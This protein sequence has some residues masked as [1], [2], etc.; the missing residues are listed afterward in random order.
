MVVEL[1]ELDELDVVV[2]VVMVVVDGY[3]NQYALLG[4]PALAPGPRESPY[5]CLP[6]EP[7]LPSACPTPIFGPDLDAFPI[8]ISKPPYAEV[9]VVVLDDDEVVV[10][11]VEVDVVDSVVVV[12][13]VPCKSSVLGT[14]LPLI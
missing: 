10:K 12:V 5:M 3:F 6:P 2:V 1:D 13:L 11:D 7:I 14:V 8:L 4:L 9:V